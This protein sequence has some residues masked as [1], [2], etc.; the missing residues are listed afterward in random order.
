MFL[1]AKLPV[2]LVQAWALTRS[3]LNLALRPNVA[4]A[5]AALE[6]WWRNAAQPA[7]RPTCKTPA[8]S[9]K[10]DGTAR[11]PL[12]DCLR[13]TA[14]IAHQF[15][16]GAGL[17]LVGVQALASPDWTGSGHNADFSLHRRKVG[18]VRAGV[19]Q[20]NND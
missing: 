2:T 20:A 10:S 6:T 3:S 16:A 1:T 17:Q 12:D 14:G 7:R 13:S 18:A 11:K 15:F 19:D 9:Q 4:S 5:K 8:S